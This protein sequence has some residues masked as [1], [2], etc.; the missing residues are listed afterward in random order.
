MWYVD[1]AGGY[2]GHLNPSTGAIDEWLV[3][4][5]AD[6]RPYGMAI[7][8]VVRVISWHTKCGR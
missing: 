6:A 7:D 1:Y 4:G 3:P 8:D 5:G 2:L